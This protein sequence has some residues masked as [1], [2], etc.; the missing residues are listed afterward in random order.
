[1]FGGFFGSFGIFFVINLVLQF[2]LE[3]FGLA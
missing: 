2:V 1:M 3:I